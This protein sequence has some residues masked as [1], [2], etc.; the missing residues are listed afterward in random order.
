MVLN[1]PLSAVIVVVFISLLSLTR[2][3]VL[4]DENGK[5]LMSHV[6]SDSDSIWFIN[7]FVLVPNGSL[8]PLFNNR[9][10]VTAIEHL[11]SLIQTTPGRILSG[12]PSGLVN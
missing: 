10:F 2:C 1:K 4:K 11:L 8:I 5:L 7:S 3:A 12:G 9:F 6:V